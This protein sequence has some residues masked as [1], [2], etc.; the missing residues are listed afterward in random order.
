MVRSMAAEI[1][2]SRHQHAVLVGVRHRDQL[3]DPSN[4][5]RISRN[6]LATTDTELRLIAS[7]AIIGLSSR[8]KAG[9]STPAAT[10]TPM[11]L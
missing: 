6:A 7:A 9:Y 11:A 5:E 1:D 3:A 8:P 2:R 4:G 10:G